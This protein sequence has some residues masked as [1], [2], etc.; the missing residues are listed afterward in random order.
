MI[1]FQNIPNSQIILK[2]MPEMN[3]SFSTERET[4][5]SLCIL[6]SPTYIFT[7]FLGSRDFSTSALIRRSRKGRKTY[8][9]GANMVT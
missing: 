3:Q 5:H 7:S 9:A 6:L 4:Y 1:N 8:R 2:S